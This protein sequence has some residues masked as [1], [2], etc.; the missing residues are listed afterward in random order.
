MKNQKIYDEIR[1]ESVRIWAG[2]KDL[3][4]V[5]SKLKVIESLENDENRIALMVGMFDGDNKKELMSNLSEEA[6]E[7][8]TKEI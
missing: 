8:I 3:N 2:Y 5:M 7:T 6:R 1:R 4:Y